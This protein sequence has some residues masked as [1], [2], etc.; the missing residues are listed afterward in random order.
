VARYRLRFPV[1]ELD[2]PQG[3]A[4]VGR[5]SDCWLTL[6][7]PLISRRHASF[8]VADDSL[9]ID[10][11]GS[12]NGVRINERSITGRVLLN[13]GDRIKLG[14]QQLLVR[15]VLPL[16]A[17]TRKATGF[18]VAC[19][20]CGLPY[21]SENPVCPKCGPIVSEPIEETTNTVTSAWSIE[22]ILETLKRAEARGR[23][24]DVERLLVRAKD[25]LGR[26]PERVDD[27]RL[28]QLADSAVRFAILQA[29]L[30]WARWALSLYA[31]HG[32]VPRP[33]V[34]LALHQL[35]EEDRSTL[36]PAVD[37]V[38]RSLSEGSLL[39]PA[40]RESVRSLRVLASVR[41]AQG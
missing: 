38:V 30:D 2:L 29:N 32:L 27:R 6:D 16:E 37:E 35:S 4:T 5:S 19:P 13:D 18:L 15:K 8:V 3:E 21:S 7:D 39:D 25:E 36:A 22:L 12:R 41:R 28:D 23:P 10:D 20:G 31:T 40:D 34:G 17:R 26:N 14:S 33:E 11:L 1:H 24:A 9:W